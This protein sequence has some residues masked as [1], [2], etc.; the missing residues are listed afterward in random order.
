MASAG[1]SRAFSQS[2]YTYI[3]GSSHCA[4]LDPTLN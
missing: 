4:E 3:T 2:P 1:V